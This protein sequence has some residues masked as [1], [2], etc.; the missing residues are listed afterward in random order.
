MQL[1]VATRNAHK[2]REFAEILGS[3][4]DCSGSDRGS[5][6]SRSGRRLGHLRRE[7]D[8]ESGRR[9]RSI[10]GT[11]SSRTIRVW[12]WTLWRARRES[13]RRATPARMRPTRKNVAKLLRLRELRRTSDRRR[14]AFSLLAGARARWRD[15]GDIRRRRRRNDRRSGRAAEPDSDTILS[16]IPLG[17]D[18]DFRRTSCRLRKTGSVTV[19]EA[20]RLCKLA[21]RRILIRR[22]SRVS[23]PAEAERRGSAGGRAPGAPA[24]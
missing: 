13:I 3:E 23:V 1:I 24:A 11:W 6:N 18:A 14:G 4:F 9:S 22:S 8:P 12:K 15:P 10:S 5:R 20:I 2:T 17:F 16:F 19:R 7:C 21:A